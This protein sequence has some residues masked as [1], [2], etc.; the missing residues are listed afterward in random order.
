MK[1]QSINI[2]NILIFSKTKIVINSMRF[3][4][5][6]HPN[7]EEYRLHRLPTDDVISNR[8]P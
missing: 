5:L 8:R 3:R 7:I 2:I 6:V 4:H 1:K